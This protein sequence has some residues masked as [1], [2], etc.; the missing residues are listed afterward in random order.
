MGDPA[1]SP[2]TLKYTCNGDDGTWSPDAG[3]YSDADVLNDES[4]TIDA[5]P[6]CD[7]EPLK[8]ITV[9]HYGQPGLQIICSDGEV[10][11]DEDA[12]DGSM[13]I[14][15]PN[16]CLLLCDLN[17]VLT[18]YTDWDKEGAGIVKWFKTTA[19]DQDSAPTNAFGTDIYCWAE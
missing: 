8:G 14:P 1:T 2:A 18:I 11:T 12:G 17:H 6:T 7:G 13:M 16:T 15:S 5:E 19:D 4:T 9:D 3:T 10:A